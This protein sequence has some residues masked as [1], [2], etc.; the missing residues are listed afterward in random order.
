MPLSDMSLPPAVLAATTE[1]LFDVA[2]DN[3]AM[4][5]LLLASKA[6]ATVKNYTSCIRRYREFAG[7]ADLPFLPDERRWLLSSSTCMPG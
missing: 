2:P 5:S 4:V 6:P 7:E 3:P 1:L